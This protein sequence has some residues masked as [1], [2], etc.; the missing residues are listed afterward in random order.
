MS[1][2]AS[3]TAEFR[4]FH[5]FF[6][7]ARQQEGLYLGSTSGVN[8]AAAVAAAKQLGPGHTIVTILCD[9]GVKYQ[10][11]L[12]NKQWLVEKGLTAAAGF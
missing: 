11:R 8:V 2:L 4:V 3:T 12:F 9:S 6:V 5:K 1:T 7:V 10:S